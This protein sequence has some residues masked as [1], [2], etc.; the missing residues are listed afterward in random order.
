[1]KRKFLVVA[2]ISMM[3][4]LVGC[5]DTDITIDLEKNGSGN[6]RVEMKGPEAILGTLSEE[7]IE[8]LRGQYDQVEVINSD[9]ISGCIVTSKIKDISEIASKMPIFNEQTEEENK[10]FI[11]LNEEKGLFSSTYTVNIGLKDII[12]KEMTQEEQLMMNYAGANSNVKLHL[13]TPNTVE[14]SNATSSTKENDKNVYN[15]DYTLSN[16]GNANF[17][18]KKT[19]T[20]NIVITVIL[21]I[22]LI[23][24][25]FIYIRRKKD[26]N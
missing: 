1:M 7:E 4:M 11:Y 2:I 19:N 17:T 12:F 24:G 23:V 22:A 8:S 10:N 5:V 18:I 20:L 9:G 13:K 26:I 16:V 6:V 3:M 14:S 21:A 25:A 15:W